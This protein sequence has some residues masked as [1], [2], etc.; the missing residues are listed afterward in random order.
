[1]QHGAGKILDVGRDAFTQDLGILVAER[2]VEIPDRRPAHAVIFV[3][4]ERHRPVAHEGRDAPHMGPARL[5]CDRPFGKA[6]LRGLGDDGVHGQTALRF[7]EKRGNRG[8][9]YVLEGCRRSETFREIRTP[10]RRHRGYLRAMSI[11]WD[12]LLA[13]DTAQELHEALAGAR[14]RALRFDGR[15]RDIVMF[16]RSTTLLWR[17]HPE[18]GFP[19]LLDALEP[20]AS[21]LRLK[22]RVRRVYAPLDE[23]IVI[24]ELTAERHGRGPYEVVVELLGNQL[25]AIA[26]EGHARTIRHVLRRREGRRPARVGAPYTPPTSTGRVGADGELSRSDWRRM[27]DSAPPEDQRRELTRHVAWVSALNAG[28]FLTAPVDTPRAPSGVTDTPEGGYDAWIAAVSASVPGGPVV[29]D[30][31]HG[32]QPY[33]FALIGP[34]HRNVPTLLAAFE[35]C[36]V[37]SA[38]AGDTAPALSL[39]PEL[40]ASLEDTVEHRRRRVL[41]L[42]AEADG[43]DDPDPLRAIGDLILARYADIPRGAGRLVLTDFSG[44]EVT[45][46]LDPELPP[47]ENA[48]RYYD[49]ASRSE[50]AAVR[51][52]GLL[53]EATDDRDRMNTLLEAARAGTVEAATVRAA[54]PPGPNRRRRGNTP[55]ALPYRTFHTSGGIEIRVGRGS[56]HNDDLT[57][58]HSSPNDVWLHA[59]HTAG[60]HVILRWSGPGKPPARDLEEAATLAALHSKA[61]TAGSVPV[62]W[63]LRKYVRKPRGSAPGSVVADRAQTAFVRP[64]PALLESLADRR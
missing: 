62:D 23:R 16:F 26:T 22:A 4:P 56:R 31:A 20:E 30:T 5:T 64:D 9:W 10:A 63:T 40:L 21:D 49:R 50:R 27:V 38:A 17:L 42:Q 52:P 47:H 51:L 28:H 12:S 59:R 34:H 44:E 58:H 57:F 8:Q 41:R 36:A 7:R 19:L 35:A 24:F 2:V 46:E 33:P 14:L 54:L 61:R 37:E 1:M 55:P 3:E 29:L 6:T 15:V 25:N 53:E 13:R 60:A 43:L 32:P 45:V 48:S 18:R 11:R 39:E